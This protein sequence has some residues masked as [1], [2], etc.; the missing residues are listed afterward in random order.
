M[1]VPNRVGVCFDLT[2]NFGGSEGV[3]CGV[4]DD[5]NLKQDHFKV[6]MISFYLEFGVGVLTGEFFGGAGVI[7]GPTL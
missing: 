2:Q 1:S 6:T 3:F 5:T 7:R 4:F